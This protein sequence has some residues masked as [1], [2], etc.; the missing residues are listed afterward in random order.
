MIESDR[1]SVTVPASVAGAYEVIIGSGILSAELIAELSGGR[2]NIIV[3]DSNV[4]DA[5]WIDSISTGCP[6]YVI[7]PPGEVSKHI[8]KVVEIV[9]MMESAA[10]GRDCIITSIGGGT[11]GDMA[12]FAAAIFKRGVPV[13][14][15]PT[16]TVSQADSSIGGKTGVDSSIS[17]NAFGCFHHPSAVIVDTDTLSTLPERQYLSGLSESVKHALIM[18][19]D[20][21]AF[22][23]SNLCGL[24]ARDSAVLVKLAGY[25]CRIKASVV[26]KD[27]TEKNMRRILNYGHTIG[28]AVET[29]SGFELLHGECVAIGMTVAAMIELELG[30]GSEDRLERVRAILS[31]LK[32]PTAIP[33][34]MKT[35][36]IL[37]L[38]SH[39]KKAVGGWPRFALIEGV[40]CAYVKDGQWAHPV[41]SEIVKRCIEAG[42]A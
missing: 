5:G 18:D 30:I 21:F 25:N 13:L 24:L 26:E 28:H 37:S 4:A 1:Q 17:K 11:V 10:L 20:Y 2:K 29:L 7:N 27:P 19:E 39:D 15:V 40:G 12:G 9:E 8:G 23:E 14:Q 35:T 3:T 31:S 38:L 36:D 6:V 41:S 34:G 32:Q 22:L 16:T 33:A 42:R